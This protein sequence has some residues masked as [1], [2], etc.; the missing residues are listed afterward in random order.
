M[1]WLI[2]ANSEYSVSESLI[3]FVKRWNQNGPGVYLLGEKGEILITVEVIWE[4]M[5]S[6]INVCWEFLEIS[7]EV[8]NPTRSLFT[9]KNGSNNFSFNFFGNF[10]ISLFYGL[11]Q[12]NI[13]ISP[14]MN[15]IFWLF[16]AIFHCWQTLSTVLMWP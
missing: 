2:N 1:I 15:V 4:N 14:H 10:Q 7:L 12:T 9:F 5:H 13:K 3:R 6:E 11:C 16:I 8:W